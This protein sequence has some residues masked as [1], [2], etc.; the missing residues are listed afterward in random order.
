MWV[1]FKIYKN[2]SENLRSIK[3]KS[4]TS[5]NRRFFCSKFGSIMLKLTKKSTFSLNM[6]LRWEKQCPT[7]RK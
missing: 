5:K 1:N 3:Q 2:K 7:I 4:K 6:L